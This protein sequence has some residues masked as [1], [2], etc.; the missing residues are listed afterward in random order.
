MNPRTVR[1]RPPSL[2]LPGPAHGERW[3]FWR[4][5]RGVHLVVIH[6]S[7]VTAVDHWPNGRAA[8]SELDMAFSGALSTKLS[9]WLSSEAS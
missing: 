6:D 9:T 7:R 5:D 2:I 8:W 1:T 3:A 4:D